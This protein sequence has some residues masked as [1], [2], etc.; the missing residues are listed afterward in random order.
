M[1]VDRDLV[2]PFKV[3]I[4]LTD[5]VNFDIS[6][7]LIYGAFAVTSRVL[8]GYGPFILFRGGANE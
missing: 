2:W 6:I 8:M 5:S 4:V 7:S 3:Q 1:A